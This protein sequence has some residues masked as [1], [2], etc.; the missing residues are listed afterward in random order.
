MLLTLAPHPDT[1][2]DA[3]SRIA[4]EA[5]RIGPTGLKL[6]YTAAGD[7]GQV[8][9]PALAVS[10]RADEL[11]RHSCFE[12]FVRAGEGDGYVEVNLSPSSQW[13][14][15]DFDGYRSGMAA[16]EGFGLAAIA[17]ARN[18]DRY[19]LE[20]A[21]DLAGLP[22]GRPWRLALSAVIETVVG[23]K[24]YW[25]LAHPPGQPDF[26]HPDAFTLVLDPP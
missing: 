21:L 1:P 3:V 17:Q 13:A 24:C 11:W 7:L 6:T 12:A 20:A 15:Y 25:A 9:W 14:A 22:P 10:A 19:V 16:R 23:G 4:V 5:A 18:D 8:L 2:C 26:H